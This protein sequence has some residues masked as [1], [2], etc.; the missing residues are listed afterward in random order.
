MTS[1][2]NANARR[3]TGRRADLNRLH[4]YYQLVP[5]LQTPFGYIFWR[6]EQCKAK[7]DIEIERRRWI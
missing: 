6:L 2:P 1:P 7:I 3:L 5:T 4:R